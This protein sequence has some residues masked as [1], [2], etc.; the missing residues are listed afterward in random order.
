[1]QATKYYHKWYGTVVREEQV[2]A[3]SQMRMKQGSAALWSYCGIV[4]MW[5]TGFSFDDTLQMGYRYVDTGDE[6]VNIQVCCY[7]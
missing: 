5:C 4:D 1:M 7:W 6:K 2:G 3:V